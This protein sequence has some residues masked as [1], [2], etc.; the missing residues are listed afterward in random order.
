MRMQQN[1]ITNDQIKQ[2]HIHQIIII[3]PYNVAHVPPTMVQVNKKDAIKLKLWCEPQEMSAH[4]CSQA[5]CHCN[6]RAVGVLNWN[7]QHRA[8]CC[9]QERDAN[10]E[11]SAQTPRGCMLSSWVPNM[12]LSFEGN[13]LC[14]ASPLI[15][16]APRHKP[17]IHESTITLTENGYISII[18]RPNS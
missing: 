6:P 2:P 11:G 16:A 1:N 15:C 10:Y 13:L 9:K 17:C 14:S 7:E 4:R 3:L 18:W 8:R 5:I 12:P